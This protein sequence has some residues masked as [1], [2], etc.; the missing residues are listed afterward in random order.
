MH[1]LRQLPVAIM[2]VPDSDSVKMFV[3]QIPRTMEE[4]EL[5]MMMEEYGPVYQLGIIRDRGSGQHRG[6]CLYVC[7]FLTMFFLH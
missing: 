5:K 1:S 4:D 6:K 3:G 2:A 7:S